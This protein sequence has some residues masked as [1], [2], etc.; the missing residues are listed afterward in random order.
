MLHPRSGLIDDSPILPRGF[1][2]S[3]QDVLG[4]IKAMIKKRDDKG[5]A[6]G[7]TLGSS[8][9]S[10]TREFF[11]LAN[12]PGVIAHA[13]L[14][15]AS[16]ESSSRAGPAVFS[17]IARFSPSGSRESRK[18]SRPRSGRVSLAPVF[19]PSNVSLSTTLEY[20]LSASRS[21]ARGDLAPPYRLV[22]IAKPIPLP[23]LPLGPRIA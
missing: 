13:R 5:T 6:R 12:W 21:L 17:F 1:P 11:N 15:L 9:L 22:A 20:S 18:G 8:I 23:P 16:S 7:D 4:A 2:E 3:E 14:F 19:L 10:R